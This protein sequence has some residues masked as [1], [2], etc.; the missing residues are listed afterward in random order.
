MLI[1]ITVVPIA[2]STS[3]ITTEKEEADSLTPDTYNGFMVIVGWYSSAHRLPFEITLLGGALFG[4][5]YY[6]E[7]GTYAFISGY[8]AGRFRASGFIGICRLGFVCGVMIGQIEEVPPYK[9]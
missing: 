4:F 5:V 6:V 2:Q 3:I 7:E 8:G 1:V 9:Y